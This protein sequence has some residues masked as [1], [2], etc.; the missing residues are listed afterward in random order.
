WRGER[1]GRGDRRAPGASRDVGQGDRQGRRPAPR[2]R[3]AGA[4]P[5]G[6]WRRR[7]GGGPRLLR[8][9]GAHGE[10]RLLAVAQVPRDVVSGVMTGAAAD[11]ARDGAMTIGIREATDAD[12]PSIV[13]IVN[14]EIATSPFVWGE[15]PG[16]VEARR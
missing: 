4:A 2:H 8:R 15:H 13:E 11:T 1:R 16:T 14:R 12:L 5:D 9:A 3:E 10:R 6:R 7:D